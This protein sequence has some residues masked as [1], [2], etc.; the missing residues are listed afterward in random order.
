[1]RLMSITIAI[2]VNDRNIS[3]SRKV[4]AAS[5][6]VS[7]VG[8]VI[9]VQV[10]LSIFLGTCNQIST[11]RMIFFSE[12]FHWAKAYCFVSLS[13]CLS[14]DSTQSSAW[15]VIQFGILL[16]KLFASVAQFL[17]ENKVEMSGNYK[18]ILFSDTNHRKSME[19]FESRPFSSETQFTYRQN[20]FSSRCPLQCCGSAF[21]STKASD[22]SPCPK[23][24][25]AIRLSTKDTFALGRASRLAR[26]YPNITLRD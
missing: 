11:F 15:D 18:E 22:N 16:K 1:M 26:P 8:T 5:D 24:S 7:V 6:V 23:H 17:A 12:T 20:T 9:S 3:T 19:R 13:L 10:T 21:A 2:S 4:V 14:S 25:Q